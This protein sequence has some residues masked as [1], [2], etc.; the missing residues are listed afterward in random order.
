MVNCQDDLVFGPRHP[1]L[2]PGGLENRYDSVGELLLERCWSPGG[3]EME[4]SLVTFLPIGLA[5]FEKA[6]DSI[7]ES[8]REG[9]RV[10]GWGHCDLGEGRNGGGVE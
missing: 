8:D 2:L 4:F 10:G 1:P 9:V 6:D 5:G 3:G 7:V